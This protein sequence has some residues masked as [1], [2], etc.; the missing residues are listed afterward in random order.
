[1][2]DGN[3]RVTRSSLP[4]ES[5]TTPGDYAVSVAS[6]VTVYVAFGSFLSENVLV[7]SALESGSSGG[8]ENAANASEDGA[9]VDGS[10]DI[11]SPLVIVGV[12][13]V[14]LLLGGIVILVLSNRRST[15]S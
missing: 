7:S 4:D 3:Y 2:D 13:V 6:D 10:D 14:V 15:E 11:V 1:L 5:L 8:F 12:V 9:F